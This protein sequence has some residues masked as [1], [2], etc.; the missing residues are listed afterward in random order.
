MVTGGGEVVGDFVGTTPRR[1][2]ARQL[3]A[4]RLG[5]GLTIEEVATR[6]EKSDSTLSRIEKAEQ[7]LDIVWL[8][9][10]LDMFGVPVDEWEP[11]LQLC[12]QSRKRGWWRDFGLDDRGYVGLEAGASLVR[13]FSLTAV[14]GLLQTADYARALFDSAMV[15]MS[16]ATRERQIAVRA[17]R[18]RRL[19]IEDNP[20]KLVAI[21]DES[22]L[23]RPVGGVAVLQA[24]LEHLV[25]MSEVDTVTLRVLPT[26]L[27]AYSGMDTGTF[28]ILTF[29]DMAEP[30][31]VYVEYVSGSMH[32]ERAGEVDQ[33][34]LTFNRL[35]SAAL[36]PADSVALLERLIDE[37]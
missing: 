24:Q 11:Y 35:R 30:D 12:R 20:L 36:S 2:L 9:E 19:R 33:S 5:A 27:G 3:R 7:L 17:I 32:I 6:L 34:R 8:R 15:P 18:Q 28:L 13:E 22:V 4:L 16:D 1:Q 37:L 21:V 31:L 29:P 25:I 26:A 23:R 14:P 10:M